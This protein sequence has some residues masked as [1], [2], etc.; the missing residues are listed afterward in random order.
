[1]RDL[2]ARAHHR[3][4]T[5][6]RLVVLTKYFVSGGRSST[7][8]PKTYAGTKRSRGGGGAPLS[9]RGSHEPPWRAAH[10]SDT[11]NRRTRTL[12]HGIA[13]RYMPDD[14]RRQPGS[15]LS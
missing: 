6:R 4:C 11:R 1:V 10:A 9:G 2:S 12:L 3:C 5:R 8:S 14:T 7:A 13:R 15:R